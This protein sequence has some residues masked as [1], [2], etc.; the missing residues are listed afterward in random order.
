MTLKGRLLIRNICMVF[1]RYLN[2][3]PAGAALLEN[4]LR[5]RDERHQPGAGVHGGPA[6]QR[7]LRRHVRRHRQRVFGGAGARLPGAGGDAAQ[8]A[9]RARWR[10]VLAYNSGRIASYAAAGALAGGLA[11]GARALAGLAAL[12]TA[13]YW[14]ANLMLVVLGLYLMDAWRGLARLE[15]LGPARVAPH[16]AGHRAAAAARFAASSCWRWAACGAGCR[17]GWSTAC[18]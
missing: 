17:A 15:Q 18:C 12:E 9:G 6:R 1:D 3:Q 13:G 16:R 5:R 7:A 4:H 8:R 14:L 10:A 11:G 2:E